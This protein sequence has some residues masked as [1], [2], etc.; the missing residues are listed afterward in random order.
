MYIAHYF[1]LLPLICHLSTFR[2]FAH[3]TC[4]LINISINFSGSRHKHLNGDLR[5]EKHHFCGAPYY[6]QTRALDVLQIQLL[7]RYIYIYI[8]VYAYI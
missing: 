5:L 1:I 6:G 3:T 2:R 7:L 8:Y 4:V